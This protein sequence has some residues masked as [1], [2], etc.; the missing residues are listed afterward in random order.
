M[1]ACV[2][3]D[4]YVCTYVCIYVSVYVRTGKAVG[5]QK[6]PKSSWG[7]IENSGNRAAQV[8][9][10]SRDLESTVVRTWVPSAR[11]RV[12]EASN[13]NNNVNQKNI[14][15]NDNNESNNNNNDNNNN[16]INLLSS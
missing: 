8:S 14:N 16:I 15:K 6:F 11:T 5:T 7:S 12:D 2:C 4:V 10:G 9:Q 13:N 3:M 1:Y